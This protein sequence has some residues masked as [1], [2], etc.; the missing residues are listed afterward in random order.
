M[1]KKSM[2]LMNS[3]KQLVAGD[4]VLFRSIYHKNLGQTLIGYYQSLTQNKHG[5]YET[6]HAGICVG[7]DENGPRIAHVTGGK[8]FGYAV[9]N[10]ADINAEDQENRSLLVY[11]HYDSTYRELIAKK[12]AAVAEQKQ[13]PAWTFSSALKL[14]Y[15]DS[16][17]ATTADE[18]SLSTI[19]SKFTIEILQQVTKNS[20]SYVNIHS[21]STPKALEAEL[22]KNQNYDLFIYTGSPDPKSNLGLNPYLTLKKT[23]EDELTRLAQNK[24]N[25]SYVMQKYLEVKA[26]L[27]KCDQFVKEETDELN[28]AQHLLREVMPK[29]A[30]NTGMGLFKPTSYKNVAEQARKLGIFRWE[31]TTVK[32]SQN[33]F[34]T[35]L[36]INNENNVRPSISR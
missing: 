4:V 30:V 24:D 33:S 27:F 9:Q 18:I 11:R 17:K 8:I 32:Q 35:A 10:L 3:T 1:R 21:T 19:C 31:E 20:T 15:T 2:K 26:A 22:H 12:A 7:H 25:N 36:R 29:L 28:K 34:Q 23:V 6:V 5:H 16:T 14:L 13:R